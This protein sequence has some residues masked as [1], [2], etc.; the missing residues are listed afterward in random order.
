MSHD[1]L[2]RLR[3]HLSAQNTIL[4]MMQPSGR[5]GRPVLALAIEITS[6]ETKQSTFRSLLNKFGQ[7]MYNCL[8]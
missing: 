5:I 6:K 7:T 1:D 2:L 4:I 8:Q 3:L